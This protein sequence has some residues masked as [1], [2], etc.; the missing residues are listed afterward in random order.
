MMLMTMTYFSFSF[1]H[2][3]LLLVLFPLF[4]PSLFFSYAICV[5]DGR[6]INEW[7]FAQR[8]ESRI[9]YAFFIGS[10]RVGVCSVIEL[11]SPE[12]AWIIMYQFCGFYFRLAILSNENGRIL[13]NEKCKYIYLIQQQQQPI[14]TVLL[15]TVYLQLSVYCSCW[16]SFHFVHTHTHTSFFSI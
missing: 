11:N 4:F 12:S 16:P 10:K 14:Y 3:Q 15:F 2:H 8:I 7:L 6:M 5:S 9:P 13:A 1:Y